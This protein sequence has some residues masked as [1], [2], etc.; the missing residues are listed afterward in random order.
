MNLKRPLPRHNIIKLSSGKERHYIL[1]KGLIQ[2]NDIT[3]INIY[4]PNSRPP[5]YMKLAHG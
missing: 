2:K 5:K 1:L 3:I 4:A